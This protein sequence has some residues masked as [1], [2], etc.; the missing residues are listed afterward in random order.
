M[1]HEG[2][3]DTDRQTNNIYNSPDCVCVCEEDNLFLTITL[4]VVIIPPKHQCETLRLCYIPAW[5]CSSSCR[6]QGEV[7]SQLSKVISF[8]H[9]NLRMEKE[10]E[11]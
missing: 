9:Y 3:R 11:L 7:C 2:K 4:L 1:K 10:E 6:H 8:F 5:W